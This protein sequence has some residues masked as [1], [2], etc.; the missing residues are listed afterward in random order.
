MS[1]LLQGFLPSPLD[2]RCKDRC[3]DRSKDRSIVGSLAGPSLRTSSDK[4][5]AS[6]RR[7]MLADLKFPH[8][9]QLADQDIQIERGGR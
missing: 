4:I 2:T 5:A 7:Q 1:N 9:L 8:P 6:K 3:G